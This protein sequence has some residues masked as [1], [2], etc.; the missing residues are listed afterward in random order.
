MQQN[1]YVYE[2]YIVPTNEVFYVGKGKGKRCFDTSHRN[3]FFKDMYKSHECA[4]R[5]IE[6][7]LDE[8]TA[9]QR[10]I[11]WINYY[12]TK[13]NY[14]LTNVTDGGEGTSG[15]IPSKEIKEKISAASK[16]RWNDPDWRQKVIANR[17]LPSSTY[18]S[19][20]FKDKISKLVSG[21]NNPNYKHYWSEEQKKHMSDLV[22]SDG[23]Y[24]RGKNPKAKAV[25]CKETGQEFECI[26]DACEEYGIK[27]PTSITFCL[28]N[29]NRTAKGL[30]FEL[31]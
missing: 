5:K 3:K 19:Q 28:Q 29:P 8:Q 6:E 27:S 17:Y 2:W 31:I 24:V 22:R 20:E 7:N 16:E 30:H 15:Y 25:R 9:F 21:E 18:Q 4:V 12:R 11:Y 23:R 1:Y 26:I 10:E 14:R 13:T